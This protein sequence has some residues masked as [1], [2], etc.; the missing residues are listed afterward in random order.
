MSRRA[1]VPTNNPRLDLSKTYSYKCE[2]ASV[3]A[4]QS[5][6]PPLNRTLLPSD[7]LDP[8]PEET[9][10]ATARQAGGKNR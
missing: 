1:G 3:A 7:L 6:I 2:P 10:K 9:E 4:S 8:Y 5:L